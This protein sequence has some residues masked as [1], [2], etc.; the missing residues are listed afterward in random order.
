MGD[1]QLMTYRVGIFEKSQSECQ[2]FDTSWAIWKVQ[3]GQDVAYSSWWSI[4][5][6][7]VIFR[8]RLGAMTSECSFFEAAPRS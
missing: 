1:W 8:L 6:R 7:V 3:L 2:L 4:D 5:S